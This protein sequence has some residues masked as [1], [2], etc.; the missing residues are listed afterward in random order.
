MNGNAE[1]VLEVIPLLPLQSTNVSVFLSTGLSGAQCCPFI[2]IYEARP[3]RS[4][5]KENEVT[6]TPHDLV[7]CHR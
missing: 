3:A 5:Q 6:A 2:R 1:L 4:R 7:N